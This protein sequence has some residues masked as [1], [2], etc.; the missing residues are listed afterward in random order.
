MI[1]DVAAIHAATPVKSW[2]TIKIL[3]K[4]LENCCT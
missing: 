4:S 2:E 3:V 1:V